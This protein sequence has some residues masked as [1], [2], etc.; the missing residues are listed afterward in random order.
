MSIWVKKQG[1]VNRVGCLFSGSAPNLPVPPAN[2]D[3]YKD[4]FVRCYTHRPASTTHTNALYD[5]CQGIT[6]WKT[7]NIP[8]PL[9]NNDGTLDPRMYSDYD[10]SSGNIRVESIDKETNGD[11]VL[12]FSPIPH[13]PT[14][15]TPG[16]FVSFKLQ[17]YDG[18]LWA[19]GT[20]TITFNPA[21][22]PLSYMIWTFAANSPV[23]QAYVANE[24]Y[25]IRMNFV[26]NG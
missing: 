4:A 17:K 1:N 9:R 15:A 14:P 24:F 23:A 19:E 2:I 5:G 10:I 12:T 25:I 18:S 26:V 22:D 3:G 11:L 21:V 20:P 8:L 16:T 13:W 6:A 7:A